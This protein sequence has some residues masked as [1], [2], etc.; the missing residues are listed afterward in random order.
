ML[1]YSALADP[2]KSAFVGRIIQEQ[3]YIALSVSLPI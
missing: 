3:Q 1:D 2:C